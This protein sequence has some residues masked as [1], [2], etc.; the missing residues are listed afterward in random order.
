MAALARWTTPRFRP[1]CAGCSPG[2]SS[3]RHRK[4]EIFTKLVG[5]K[6]GRLTWPFDSKPAAAKEFFE[7][8]LDV[9][10]FRESAARLGEAQRRFEDLCGQRREALGAVE[11]RLRERADSGEKLAA[12]Q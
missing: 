2:K 5:V 7:P 11:E 8:L 6:Q 9:E 1:S 10:V 4:A 12:K 3:S